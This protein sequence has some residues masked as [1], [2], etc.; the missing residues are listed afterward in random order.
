MSHGVKPNRWTLLDAGADCDADN[1][2]S[3]PALHVAVNVQNPAM[4]TMLLNAGADVNMK[5]R[6]NGGETPLF[7]AVG[8]SSDDSRTMVKMPKP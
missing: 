7:L 5:A 6:R 2:R 3:M 1:G 8:H 4:V